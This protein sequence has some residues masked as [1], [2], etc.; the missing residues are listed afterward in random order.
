MSFPLY[1]RLSNNVPDKDLTLKQKKYILESVENIDSNGQELLYV[2]IKHSSL[3][4]KEYCK[5]LIPY[6]GNDVIKSNYCRD[7]TWDLSKFPN[8]L[9]HIILNFLKMHLCNMNEEKERN[10]SF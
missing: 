5:K 1:D 6:N 3:Q 10:F 7:I 8:K 9:K 4:E 2:L